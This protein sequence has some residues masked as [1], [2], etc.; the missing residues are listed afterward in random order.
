[1][2]TCPECRYAD[3]QMLADKYQCLSC[4]AHFVHPPPAPKEK[5]K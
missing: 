3:T 4:G 5:K 1:M 2:V